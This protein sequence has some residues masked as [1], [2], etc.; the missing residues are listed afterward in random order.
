MSASLFAPNLFESLFVLVRAVI[1]LIANLLGVQNSTAVVYNAATPCDPGASPVGGLGCFLLNGWVLDLLTW[2]ILAT[3]VVT[4]AAAVQL[5]TVMWMERKFYSRLQDRYGIMLS[6]W[7]LPFRPIRWLASKLGKVSHLGTGFLQNIADG[8]KLVQ[9]EVITP[10]KADSAMFHAAPVFI[11]ASTVMIFAAFP[12]SSGMWVSNVPLSLLLLLAAFSLAPFG[13]LIAGW[14]S[15]NKYSLLGGMR[16]AAMLMSYEIPMVLAIIALIVYTGTFNILDIVRQQERPL[17]S[18]GPFTVPA[19]N[20]FSLPQFLGF[21]VFSVAMIA[22]QERLPFDIPEA[23][24]ELVEGWLTE[25]S[26]MRF[27]IVFGFKWLRGIATSGLIALLYLGGWT[28]PVWYT[29]TFDLLGHHF[30]VPIL[31]EEVWFLIRVYLIFLVFVWVS[32]T[33]PRVRI[34]QILNIGWK[35]LIPLSLLAILGA[36]AFATFGVLR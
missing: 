1:V 23:E 35:R 34:D 13:I 20:V 9:K 16:S 32:W 28:G 33:L 30:V 11:A 5:L 17:L 2:L 36:A 26:G 7:S 4:Y 29:W 12:W 3:L 8:V 10:A 24:A 22:E 6:I 18:L 14:A 19:W 27:G 15:N 31:P 25:Y 21:L